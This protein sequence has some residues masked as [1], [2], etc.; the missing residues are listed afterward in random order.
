[1]ELFR[2]PEI[3][4]QNPSATP[5][6]IPAVP[7]TPPAAG[8]A[9]EAVPRRTSP[10]ERLRDLLRPALQSK[11]GM[12]WE[13]L[14][15][16]EKYEPSEPAHP[17]YADYPPEPNAE[18]PCYKP[19]T[20][21]ANGALDPAV[22]QH[23]REGYERYFRD[24]TTW[25]EQVK[26][27]EAENQ[28]LYESGVAAVR[29]WSGRCRQHRRE[30]A[31]HNEAVERRKADYLSLLAS[32][33]EDYCRQILTAS[34]LPEPLSR[35]FDLQYV[36]QSRTL[37]IEHSLPLPQCLPRVKGFRYVKSRAELL[38]VLLS[39]TQLGPVYADVL[40]QVCLRTLHELFAADVAQGLD[41][42]VFNGWVEVTDP[43]SASQ[44]R[45]VLSVRADKEQF[46]ALNLSEMDAKSCFKALK[47]V[48]RAK[49]HNLEA[50]TP[51]MERTREV[52]GE[53]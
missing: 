33:V 2:S 43:A 28:R 29:E 1:M 30:Q 6:G 13:S 19:P 12:D 7:S 23:R 44:R 9:T 41:F 49:L 21:C 32:A 20:H 14:K 4:D 3:E 47:G 48:A 35:E 17:P 27:I 22:E 34:H 5:V 46:S 24:Y 31:E 38:D 42:I 40:Y 50:V 25:A 39:D 8:S 10:V 51:I 36:H 37:L 16:H 45:C 15:R 52:R 53:K 18:D 26:K 11:P